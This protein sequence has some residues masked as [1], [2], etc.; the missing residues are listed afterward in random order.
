MRINK[1]YSL[2]FHMDKAVLYG[3]LFRSFQA[4]TG[5]VNLLFI[6]YFFSLELQGFYYTFSS[7][8]ALQTFL[9]LGLYLVIVAFVSHNWSGLKV[10]YNYEVFGDAKQLSKLKYLLQFIG[11]WYGIGAF[12]SLFLIGLIGY[13]FLNQENASN[14]NWKSPWITLVILASIQF[15]LTPFLYFLEGCNQVA[16]VNKFRFFQILLEAIF[17]W[18]FFWLNS[19]LWVVVV[20]QFTRVTTTLWFLMIIYKSFFLSIV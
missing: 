16:S 7:L 14:I 6:S 19:E 13:F 12:V 11:S 5:L 10:D 17:A 8:M 2:L 4:G 18:L 9:E 20:I 1:I 3:F 15:F